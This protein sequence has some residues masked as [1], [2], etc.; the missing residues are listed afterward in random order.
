MKLIKLMK[1]TIFG[2]EESYEVDEVDYFWK[3]M[4]LMKLMK[5]TIFGSEES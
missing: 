3:L 1:L 4:K 5:L 2:S